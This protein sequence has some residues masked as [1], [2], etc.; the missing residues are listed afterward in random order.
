MARKALLS[1]ASSPPPPTSHN[2]P[3]LPDGP[4]NPPLFRGSLRGLSLRRER[5]G[6]GHVSMGTLLNC[7]AGGSL[8]PQQQRRWWWQRWRWVNTPLWCPGSASRTSEQRP[9]L[10]RAG[11][12]SQSGCGLGLTQWLVPPTGWSG[13]EGFWVGGVGGLGG[14]A[15]GRW[16]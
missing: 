6:A 11:S 14:A 3:R 12:G 2:A 9:T 4:A 7:A 15:L 13:V 5:S 16:N 10:T 8:A 1:L